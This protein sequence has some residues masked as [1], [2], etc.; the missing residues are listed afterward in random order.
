[1]TTIA[2]N[3][4]FVL[5]HPSNKRFSTLEKATE[6]CEKNDQWPAI[7]VRDRRNDK[8]LREYTYLYHEGGKPS[9]DCYDP[10]SAK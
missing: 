10:N 9:F 1:M 7:Q 5:L 2:T 3:A 4:V 8:F 6:W